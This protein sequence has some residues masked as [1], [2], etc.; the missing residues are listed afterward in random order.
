VHVRIE[1]L[2]KN[3]TL[4]RAKLGQRLMAFTTVTIDKGE[5]NSQ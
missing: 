4:V 3:G 5:A 1:A 2:V